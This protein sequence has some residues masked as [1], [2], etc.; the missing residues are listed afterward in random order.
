MDVYSRKQLNIKSSISISL[1]K[2]YRIN[3]ARKNVDTVF[4]ALEFNSKSKA[5]QKL[6]V[7]YFTSNSKSLRYKVNSIMECGFKSP[8][9][10]SGCIFRGDKCPFNSFRV[11]KKQNQNRRKIRLNWSLN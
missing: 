10:N 3:N 4:G 6:Y 11:R 2:N 7:T 8:I 5:T 1:S 9:N